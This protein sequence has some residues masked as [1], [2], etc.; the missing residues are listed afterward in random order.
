M[1]WFQ[2]IAGIEK[3]ELSFDFS[4]EQLFEGGERSL[5]SPPVSMQFET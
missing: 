2:D 5:S 4:E 3:T 1:S